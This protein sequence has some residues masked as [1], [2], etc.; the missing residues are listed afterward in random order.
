MNPQIWL[1]LVLILGVS[2]LPRL[3]AARPLGIDVSS[4]Q[5]NITWPSVAAAGISFAWSAFFGDC[6][7]QEV[8]KTIRSTIEQ[9]AA[10]ILFI[11]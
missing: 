8:S 1:R 4:Y 10:L 2:T 7:L 9:E 5:G 3:M 11:N 6:A